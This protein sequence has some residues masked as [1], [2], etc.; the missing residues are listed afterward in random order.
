MRSAFIAV[1][2]IILPWCVSGQQGSDGRSMIMASVADTLSSP[3]PVD[4][5]AIP[6]SIKFANAFRWNRTGPTG[7]YWSGDIA[8]DYIFRPVCVNVASYKL[9]IYNRNGYLIYESTELQKGWDGYLKNGSLAAQGVY[10]WKVTGKY[11]DGSSFSKAG[12]V[13]FIY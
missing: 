6:G 1:L 3:G 4:P 5:S 13:T 9:E 8:D 12:D 11:G 7:G 2:I 10:I